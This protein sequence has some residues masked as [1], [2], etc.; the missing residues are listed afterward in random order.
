MKLTELNDLWKRQTDQFLLWQNSLYQQA[1]ILHNEV[2]G[3]LQPTPEEWTDPKSGHKLKY[4]EL[5]DISDTPRRVFDEGFSSES[6][7]DEGELI[8]AIAITFDH[9]LDAFPKTIRHI[10]VAVRF[11]NKAP[12]FSFI[13]MQTKK[14]ESEWDPDIKNFT[15]ALINKIAS[16]LK[17]DP[18]EGPRSRS[19]IGF[20]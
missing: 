13:N 1:A 8:F 9:G 16:Y 4:V 6:L 18:F 12:Q 3:I 15:E 14:P 7:T 11:K 19:S 5:Y 17:F 2:S 10:P 20:L